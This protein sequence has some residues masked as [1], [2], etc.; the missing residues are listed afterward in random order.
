MKFGVPLAPFILGVILGDQIEINLIRAIMTDADPRLFLS[1][2]ISGCC[3]RPRWARCCSRRGST[4]ASSGER[5]RRR[6]R[7]SDSVS[8]HEISQLQMYGS[9]SIDVRWTE[10]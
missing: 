4:G 7:I 6:K 3:W 1:R 10:D 8:L 9:T 2:P 5:R